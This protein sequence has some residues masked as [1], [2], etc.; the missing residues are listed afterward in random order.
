[1][2]PTAP[3]AATDRDRDRGSRR[4]PPV[5][6]GFTS[7]RR[8]SR[9]SV[10]GRFRRAVHLARPVVPRRI[11]P[12]VDVGLAANEP[13]LKR[14]LDR[15]AFPLPRCPAGRHDRHLAPTPNPCRSF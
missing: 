7:R 2:T 4:N 8:V 5:A 12:T 11:S 6:D 9:F 13:D 3:T 10:S 14:L 15:N 1:V